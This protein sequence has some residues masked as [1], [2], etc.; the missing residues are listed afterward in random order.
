MFTDSLTCEVK[1][2]KNKITSKLYETETGF[3]PFP[4]SITNF[5]PGGK[6]ELTYSLL[7]F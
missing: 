1:K 2:G 6:L 7:L 3:T 4:D 5:I